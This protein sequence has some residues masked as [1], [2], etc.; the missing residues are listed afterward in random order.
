MRSVFLA[1][2]LLLFGTRAAD[3]ASAICTLSATNVAFGVVTG[4]TVTAAGQVTLH[5]TGNGNVNYSLSLS[6]GSSGSYTL[7][8]MT[9]GANRISYNL[10]TDTARTQIWG[11]GT[12]GSTT[13]TGQL[14]FQGVGNLTIPISVYGTYP[15]QPL[16]AP[17]SYADTITV[18]MSCAECNKPTT[19]FQVTANAQPACAIVASD[20]DFGTYSGV[21]LDRQSPMFLSCSTGSAW[22]IGL[23]QGT[24]SGATVTTRRMTGPH[25]A[26]LTYSLFR[27][28]AR[29][30]NWGN[31]VGTD[32]LLGSGT[33]LPQLITVYG[34][35]P[36]GQSPGAAG[37]YR[38]TIVVTVTF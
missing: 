13:V 21:Q 26:S 25:S 9:S 16:P 15:V 12:G 35:I 5:C 3:A 22:N 24:F 7:R 17:G 37:G 36:A 28:A 14:K 2:A 4:A 29:T 23:N 18:S 27:D 1:L 11:D 8:R 38:D 10:F 32:T 20:M 19:T 33:G 30:Q 31:T 6:T 34:R